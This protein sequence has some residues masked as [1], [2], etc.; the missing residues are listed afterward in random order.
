LFDEYTQKEYQKSNNKAANNPK[1][2]IVKTEDGPIELTTAIRYERMHTGIKPIRTKGRILRWITTYKSQSILIAE[3]IAIFVI[4]LFIKLLRK[5]DTSYI[6]ADML[7]GVNVV[8]KNNTQFTCIC[9]IYSFQFIAA[10]GD[11]ET[12]FHGISKWMGK[13]LWLTNLQLTSYYYWQN[14]IIDIEKSI[15]NAEKI[16]KNMKKNDINDDINF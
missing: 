9:E 8:A 14:N 10:L 16:M 3:I 2:F 4:S 12:T 1:N 7:N 6:R 5:C 13:K 15:I 11:I